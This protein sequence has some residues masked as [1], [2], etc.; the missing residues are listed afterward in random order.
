VAQ[1]NRLAG[2]SVFISSN[3]GFVVLCRLPGCLPDQNVESGRQFSQ[4]SVVTPFY[5]PFL[6]VRVQSRRAIQFHPRSRRLSSRHVTASKVQ[7]IYG[8]PLV[9]GTYERCFILARRS[10]WN[11][12]GILMAAPDKAGRALCQ[13]QEVRTIPLSMEGFARFL[14]SQNSRVCSSDGCGSAMELSRDRLSQVDVGA[15]IRR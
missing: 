4:V 14:L 9:I 3:D 10:Q 1:G 13:I 8:N 7:L 2:G 12:W 5:T 11:F 15:S 6:R